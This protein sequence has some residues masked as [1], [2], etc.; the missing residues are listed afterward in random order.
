MVSTAAARYNLF[1]NP[2][3]TLRDIA[4]VKSKEL[5]LMMVLNP[6]L[7]RGLFGVLWRGMMN[8]ERTEGGAKLEN[9]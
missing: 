5:E 8:W 2:Q 4:D 1:P 6:L 7:D 3:P 9:L